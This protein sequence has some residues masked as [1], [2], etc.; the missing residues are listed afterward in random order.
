MHVVGRGQGRGQGRSLVLSATDLANFLGCRHKTALDMSVAY[1]KRDRPPID[2]LLLDALRE[3][4]KEHERRYVETLRTQ[5]GSIVDLS[6]VDDTIEKIAATHD[7]M[8][9]GDRRIL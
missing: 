9:K 8:T 3:R 2:D 4:G 7:A 5:G 1:G 6:L